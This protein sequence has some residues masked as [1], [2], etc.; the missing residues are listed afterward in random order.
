MDNMNLHV[1]QAA[2]TQPEA[3]VRPVPEDGLHLLPSSGRHQGRQ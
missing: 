2:V 1:G 3:E